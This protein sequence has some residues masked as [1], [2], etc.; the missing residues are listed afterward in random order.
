MN[1][2][3]KNVRKKNEWGAEFNLISIFALTSCQQ[4]IYDNEKH[5]NIYYTR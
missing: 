2:E 5:S 1:H 3:F 4:S